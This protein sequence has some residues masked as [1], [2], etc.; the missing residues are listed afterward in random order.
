MKKKLFVETAPSDAEPGEKVQKGK[1]NRT[2]QKKEKK[3]VK[4]KSE[5]ANAPKRSRRS[6]KVESPIKPTV[7]DSTKTKPNRPS[8]SRKVS[9]TVTSASIKNNS[10]EVVKVSEPIPESEIS[11]NNCSIITEDYDDEMHKEWN[12]KTSNLM[13]EIPEFSNQTAL[14]EEDNGNRTASS[15]EIEIKREMIDAEMIKIEKNAEQNMNKKVKKPVVN[16]QS[17]Y[18]R[19]QLEKKKEKPFQIT[20]IINEWDD[21]SNDRQKSI[22]SNEEFLDDVDDSFSVISVAS[23]DGSVVF[24]G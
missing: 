13:A 3:D 21:D 17:Y 11:I 7:V 6:T 1:R 4:I 18:K 22:D 12:G 16:T 24:M 14:T 20:K 23:S 15:G 5:D 19:K 8:N 2:E 10:S 9:A